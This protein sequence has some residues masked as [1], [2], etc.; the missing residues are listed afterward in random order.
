MKSVSSSSG[1]E[2]TVTVRRSEAADAA[3][4]QRLLGPSAMAVFGR[5]SV[6]HLL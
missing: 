2:E 3:G 4:I 6:P 1:E 5:V